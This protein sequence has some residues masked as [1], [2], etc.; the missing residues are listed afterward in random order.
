MIV[1]AIETLK[2]ASEKI[3]PIR[4]QVRCI[5]PVGTCEQPQT[6]TREAAAPTIL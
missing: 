3:E 2:T 4:T 6:Q 5:E 1:S